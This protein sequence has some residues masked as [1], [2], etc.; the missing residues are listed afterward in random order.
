MKA[1]VDIVADNV[2]ERMLLNDV[3]TV[4]FTFDDGITNDI[5]DYKFDVWNEMMLSAL[6]SKDLKAV[7]FVTG[8]NKTSEKGI[9]L[10]SS[11]N[12]EG[13]K[14]ANH[15]F[16]H[17]FFHNP[18]VTVDSFE[19]ELS[20]T[21][22]VISG[23]SNF[24]HLFRFPY[25]KEGDSKE[26][27]EGFRE[28]LGKKGYSNGHVTIDAS[29]WYVNSELIKSIRANGLDDEMINKFRDFYVGHIMERASYYEDLSFS[30]TNR[31]ISHTLLLHHNLS[32]AL[33]LDDLIEA[34]EA[35]GWKVID[36]ETA[37]QDNLFKTQ[38]DVVPAGE[39]LVWSIAK[40]SG[41]Y[42]ES[43]RYPAEDSRYEAPK[44]RTLGLIE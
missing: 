16:N 30:V 21:H 17:P 36:A 20:K 25:L 28:V 27:I 15:T 19:V 10:L 9:Q 34:F 11:W 35:K 2:D 33:F 37:F 26:K 3:P 4:S 44:M 12:D 14:I 42:E 24:I 38:T 1:S 43:L 29:D 22:E 32:S 31:H 39:S 41:K 18:L 6:R 23:Y 13:H 40:A 7:F 8:S 5:L